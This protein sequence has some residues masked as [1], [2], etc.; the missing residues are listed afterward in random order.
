MVKIENFTPGR[1]FTCDS[2][3]NEHVLPERIVFSTSKN[4]EF[5]G[6]NTTNKKISLLIL[7]S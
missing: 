4:F 6:L 5:N 1:N 2:A 3:L 7:S